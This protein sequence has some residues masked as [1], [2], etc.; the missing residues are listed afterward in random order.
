MPNLSRIN[1]K[2]IRLERP[3]TTFLLNDHPVSSIVV[4]SLGLCED[5]FNEANSSPSDL[6]L[7]KV[8]L[9]REKFHDRDTLEEAKK[10][11]QC[12]MQIKHLYISE[13]GRLQA[14]SSFTAHEF[15]GLCEL[16]ITMGRIAISPTWLPEFTR[17]HPFLRKI[18]FYASHIRNRIIF[19]RNP[20]RPFLKPFV[21][22]AQRVGLDATLSIRGFAV[23]RTSPGLTSSAPEPFSDWLV[24]GLS[25]NLSERSEGER[26]LDLAHSFYPQISILTLE[27]LSGAEPF[28]C[29][30]FLFLLQIH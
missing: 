10:Y 6:D 22:E 30:F 1:L 28:V 5:L 18:S 19:T 26:I 29:F 23:T 25:L 11:F 27:N 7:A 16:T 20:L 2:R 15:P 13:N 8:I 3:V 17:G 9:D 12:G 4:E 21:E 24:S 14:N